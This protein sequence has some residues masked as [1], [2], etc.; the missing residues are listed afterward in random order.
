M[1][2][3]RVIL[4]LLIC[5]P[6]LCQVRWVA[7]KKLWVLE[8]DHTSYVAGVNDQN[9]VQNVYW[10]AQI[11][12]DQ[13]LPAARTAGEFAFESRDGLTTEEY[14]AWG[15]MRFAEPALKATFADGVRDV[16][17]Q[18][19]SHEATGET[20]TIRTR[21]IRADLAVDLVY[22]VYPRHDMVEKHARHT[23]PHEAG[24]GAGERAVGRVVR[25]RGRGLPAQLPHRALGGGDAID[26]RAGPASA[27]R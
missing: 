12:R 8:T 2:P 25:A 3:F 7:A 23:Q 26:A 13:D 19:V 4:A 6:A 22:R 17:L 20:L 16:V 5:L 18:Y 10:G 24:R 27:R 9:I 14:P 21:D 1:L 15:G 11:A